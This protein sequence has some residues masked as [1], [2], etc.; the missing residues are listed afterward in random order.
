MQHF[1][2]IVIGSGPGGQRAA[3]QAA[4]SG[5]KVCLVERNAELGGVTTHT[6]TIPS[7]TLRESILYL[8]GWRQRG[9]Y[10]DQYRLKRNVI[11]KDLMYRLTLATTQ[12]AAVIAD[13]LHR[14]EITILH[15][16]ASFIDSNTM[17]VEGPNDYTLQIRAK[18]ILLATGSS[19]RRP[20]NV[21]FDN[22]RVLDSDDILKITEIPGSIAIIGAGFIGLEYASM[23]MTLDIDVTLVH[24][25]DDIL[26]FADREIISEFIKSQ[27]NN[28]MT[29]CTGE[30]VLAI[31]PADD[32]VITR[33]QSGKLIASDIV[34]F[35]SGRLGCSSSLKLEK[36][37]LTVNNRKNLDV[38]EFYR[39]Q[40]PHIYAVGDLI[41]LPSL[42]STAMEQGRKAACHAFGENTRNGS[43]LYPLGIY[44][45]PEISMIGKTEEQLIDERI[46]YEIGVSRFQET[47]KG[48]I[49]GLQDGLLKILVSLDDRR[50]L[51]VHIV[52]ENATELIH[53]GQTIMLLDGTLENLLD[54]IF[55]YPSLAENYKIAA[56]DAWN[57][58]RL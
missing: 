3:V 38:D 4:K 50:I 42:A 7:K 21:P 48:Q 2:F 13:Q 53:V 57:R 39:T 9:F 52:G 43:Q 24:E 28:G 35:T 23:F 19:P 37:G 31:E 54:Q 30:P 6:G 27:I 22:E 51:G 29:L 40:V 8:S 58:M 47:A 10:G 20:K 46:P 36:A 12:Q 49:L 16:T 26:A 1:D 44:T 45:I 33:L 14:N 55:N 17:L 56:L 32:K 34:L 25:K 41:G 11:A 18:K 5:K 15:G